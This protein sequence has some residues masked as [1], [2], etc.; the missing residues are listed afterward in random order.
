MVLPLFLMVFAYGLGILY[1]SINPSVSIFA[2]SFLLLLALCVSSANLL[3]LKQ[4]PKALPFYVAALLVRIVM[5][6][7]QS[8]HG[9]LPMG[10]GD[11]P[12]FHANALRILENSDSLLRIFS[13]RDPSVTGTDA[14]ERL[15]ALVYHVCGVDTAYMYFVSFI[16]GE[17]T[18]FFIFATARAIATLK[19]ASCSALFFYLYPMEM[20]YSVAYLR[21]MSIQALFSISFYCFVRYLLSQNIT[22]LFGAFLFSYLTAR[23]H[24][25]MIAVMFGYIAAFAFYNP[26]QRR[27][28]ITPIKVF[29]VCALV[30]AAFST[31]LFKPAMTRFSRV[32]TIDTIHQAASH[33][34]AST[35]YISAPASPAGAILQTPIRLLYFLV[36]PLPWQVTSLGT[37][38]AFALDGAAR[39]CFLFFI[40]KN[41]R[42]HTKWE[43]KRRTLFALFFA[44]WVT[45][46]IIFS[47][48]TNNFG[49][50]MRHRLKIFAV[51]ITLFYTL[52]PRGNG[53]KNLAYDGRK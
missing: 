38:L 44:V 21:E 25:G 7:Y 42:D 53:R 34:E 15:V 17:I 40:I 19:V 47:W 29:V 6:F 22:A 8:T 9:D 18:F 48:G 12:V 13:P 20:I 43:R 11:W 50:A 4:W 30:I 3:R 28:S 35:D 24:S 5:L 52:A 39:I 49:T 41:L 23:M 16:A 36:S 26:S 31:G 1:T 37:A 14:Y 46:S 45:T 51:E 32:D 27:I 10:G 33:V 2:I